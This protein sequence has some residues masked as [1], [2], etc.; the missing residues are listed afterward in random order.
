MYVFRLAWHGLTL[1]TGTCTYKWQEASSK[2]WNCTVE[3]EEEKKKKGEEGNTD[4]AEQVQ[5]LTVAYHPPFEHHTE[6]PEG[7]LSFISSLNTVP[8]KSVLDNV[9]LHV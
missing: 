7:N 1:L 9:K 6:L 4:W 5:C 2:V 8:I 3:E